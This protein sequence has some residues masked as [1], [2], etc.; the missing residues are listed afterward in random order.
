MLLRMAARVPNW[1]WTFLCRGAA[2][3]GWWK[4]QKA[5]RQ[6]T[7]NAAIMMGREPTPD[8]VRAGLR[9][10]CRN[11]A[12]SVR[13]GK[14]SASANLK[15]VIADEVEF[16]RVEEAAKTTG[17]IVTMP[18]MGDWDLAGAWVGA[19]GLKISAVAERLPD[20][21]YKYYSA[22][23][24]KVGMTIYSHNDPEAFAKMRQD[25]QNGAVAA[26][27]ADRDLSRHGVEV[28][29]NTPSG[30]FTVKMPPGPALLARQTGA[31]IFAVVST[32]EPWGRMKIRFYPV[33][34]DRSAGGLEVTCQRIANIFCREVAKKPIDWHL[35]QRF[36]PGVV[37]E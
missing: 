1:G 8:E 27:V 33:E 9:S 25:L 23:R 12:G 26:L 31:Q 24:A 14:Y 34:V 13:L 6:W 37:P 16:A 3:W 35:M 32:Y 19:K 22:I 36:F 10:W 5:V 17:V 20:L 29:W 2:W 11:L 28:V 18:H 30:P 15:R 4:Q 21:E 7:M